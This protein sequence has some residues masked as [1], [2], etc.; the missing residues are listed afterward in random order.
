[1]NNF[2]YLGL[3]VGLLISV[4]TFVIGFNFGS[5]VQYKEMKK[6]KKLLRVLE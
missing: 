2:F 6:N 4:L 3:S 1:M 5:Y